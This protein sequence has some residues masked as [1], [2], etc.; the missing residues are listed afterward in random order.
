MTAASFWWVMLCA[1]SGTTL[2][3]RPTG[4]RV[5]V[6][7]IGRA[8]VMVEGGPLRLVVIPADKAPI[9]SGGRIELLLQVTNTGTSTIAI[10]PDQFHASSAL[11]RLQ[12]ISAGQLTAE[13]RD[14]AKHQR[15]AQHN[16]YRGSFP[17]TAP[18]VFSGNLSSIPSTTSAR[19]SYGSTSGSNAMSAAEVVRIRRQREDIKANLQRIDAWEKQSLELIE[20][21]A[22][23]PVEITPGA[24]W[25]GTAFLQ[26][27]KDAAWPLPIQ[28]TLREGGQE[29]QV[30]LLASALGEDTTR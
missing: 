27:P 20:S 16:A 6:D 25:R 1:L 26:L 17:D 5:G 3:V 12:L 22:L 19:T 11:G 8:A 14:Q 23:R 2:E 30:Q 18:T 29:L 9:L 7:S 15:Q 13:V 24:H 4:D 21:K 10:G 28:L